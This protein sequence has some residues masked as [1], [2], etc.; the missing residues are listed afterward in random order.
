MNYLPWL[1]L[2]TVLFTPA[3]ADAV[4]GKPR[5]L[6]VTLLQTSDVNEVRALLPMKQDA[7]RTGTDR[8]PATVYSSRPYPDKDNSLQV[9]MLE[10]STAFIQI[11]VTQ[12]EVHLLW[13]EADS[14]NPL[15]NIGFSSRQ[16]TSGFA[17]TADLNDDRVTLKVQHFHGS[18]QARHQG[19]ATTLTGS[20]DEWFDL[21]GSLLADESPAGVTT[22]AV[23]ND[24]RGRMR[25][26]VKV[27]SLQ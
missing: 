10:G 12:P 16:H 6:L 18:S 3:A 22:H 25:V 19:L 2:L 1:A 21:G 27:E 11:G 23:S 4:G 14:A 24:T 5:N 13:V 26:L 9:R 17:V 15:P 8:L 7:A 20:I